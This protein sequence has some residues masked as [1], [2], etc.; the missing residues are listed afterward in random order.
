MTGTELIAEIRRERPD[1]PILLAHRLRRA[2]Q[3]REHV[4][5]RVS[6]SPF[7]QAHLDQAIAEV[8]RRR[9]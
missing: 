1:L 9:R 2:A 8:M 7:L 5:S 3:R 6:T 4:R